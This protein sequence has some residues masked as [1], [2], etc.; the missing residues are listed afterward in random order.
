MYKY[1][2]IVPMSNEKYSDIWRFGIKLKSSTKFEFLNT[3]I[4]FSRGNTGHQDEIL[5]I[6]YFSEIKDK[7][8]AE[9]NI[10]NMLEVL[11]YM[12]RFPLECELYISEKEIN[13]IPNFEKTIG[14]SKLNSIELLN[15]EIQRFSKIK[16]LFMHNIK[17]VNVAQKYNYM[18]GFSE[19]AF[20]NYFKIIENI[21]VYKYN[22]DLKKKKLSLKNQN[23][24]IFLKNTIEES[25][26]IKYPDDKIKD[27]TQKLESIIINLATDGIFYKISAFCKV[28]NIDVN[29]NILHKA[30]K[31]RNK[32]AHG[33]YV[34]KEEI[35]AVYID[36]ANLSY[37]FISYN[38]FNKSYSSISIDSH[39]E[40]W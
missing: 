39:I 31:V 37:E 14:Y 38:F 9:N 17:L 35:A 7:R 24:D 1:S 21:S 33:N 2:T 5:Q 10:E 15:N 40:V 29:P 3:H 34:T 30:I 18:Y 23:M 25:L 13:N 36:I 12:L 6:S 22:I 32:I 16:P 26:E 8:S 11:S 28:Y 27:I 4:E 20:L 19:E